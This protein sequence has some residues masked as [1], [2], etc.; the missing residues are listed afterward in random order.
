MKVKCIQTKLIGSNES[1][2]HSNKVNWFKQSILNQMKAKC[3]QTKL[4]EWNKSPV[5]SNKNN[6]LK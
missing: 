3:I 1:E 4:I 2:V 5:H 6:W